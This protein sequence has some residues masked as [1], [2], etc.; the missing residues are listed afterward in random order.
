MDGREVGFVGM[1][2]EP[3]AGTSRGRGIFEV[4]E[5]LGGGL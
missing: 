4:L 5:G 3:R 1:V 2:L